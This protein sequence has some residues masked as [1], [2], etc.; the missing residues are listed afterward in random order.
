MSNIVKDEKK[1]SAITNPRLQSITDR[2]KAIS[3]RGN[4]PAK[5]ELVLC[6]DTTGSMHKVF[7]AGQRAIEEVIK[8]LDAPSTGAILSLIAYKNHGDEYLFDGERPFIA[9]PWSNKSEEILRPLYQITSEGG[10]DGLTALEDVFDYL[11]CNVEWQP[12]AKK[13]VVLIG[14]MP[15]HGVVDS[16]SHCPRRF[17]YHKSIDSMKKLGITVYSVFCPTQYHNSMG[18]DRYNK[19]T[20]FYDWI[21]EETGGRRLSLEDM[22]TLVTILVG[23]GMKETGRIDEYRDLLSQ[24]KA[25]TPGK[26]RILSALSSGKK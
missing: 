21:A 14:D 26:E 5:L 22:E 18:K 4:K 13:A 7:K 6:F 15:P 1:N 10:G 9:T 25:L 11:V 16:V 3:D 19:I 2:A 23:I 12:E 17:D 24:R 8:G 20:S